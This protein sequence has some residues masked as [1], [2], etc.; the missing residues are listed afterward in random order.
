MHAKK[1]VFESSKHIKERLHTTEKRIEKRNKV[2][3]EKEET[4]YIVD[5]LAEIKAKVTLV[6]IMQHSPLTVKSNM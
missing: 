2:V 6:E 3:I 4:G 1:S 5:G